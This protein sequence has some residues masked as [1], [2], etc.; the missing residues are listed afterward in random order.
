MNIFNS[1]GSNHTF[2]F[3][4]R[5]LFASGG[6]AD[7]KRLISYLEQRY[8]GKAILTYKGREALR[9]AL[10]A[11][12]G[13]G[14]VAINGFTC[15][16]VY[17]AIRESKNTCQYLD[18]SNESL[19]FSPEALRTAL[20]NNPSIKAVVIQNTLGTPCDIETIAGMCKEYGVALIEDLAHSIGSV[21]TSGKEAG[22]FGDLVIL[23]FSQDKVVDAVSGGA[24]IIRDQAYQPSSVFVRKLPIRKQLKDRFYPLFTYVIRATHSLGLGPLIHRTLRSL[25]VLSRPLVDNDT[26]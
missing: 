22:S 23:S 20:T 13:N 12:P 21:Y 14:A 9:L 26:S 15:W 10:E 24:L 7:E 6:S 2:S 8:G 5:M 18:I 4:V 19:N 16:A 25:H 11:I 17:Q 1:L 3:A